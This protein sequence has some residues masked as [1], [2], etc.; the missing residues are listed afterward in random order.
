M[1]RHNL[2]KLRQRK[3]MTT[4]K[5]P[6]M[7]IQ[8]Y[9]LRD[10]IKT[11][12][13]FDTTLARL[14]A[15]GVRD[16]QISGIGDIPADV[17][18]DILDKHNI[19]VCVTHKSFDRM[20]NDLDALMAEHKVIGCDAIG[21]G[22]APG[23][24]RGNLGKVREFIAR[25]EKVGRTMRDNGFTFN[26]HNHSAEF[27]RLGDSRKCMM[28]L[29]IDETDP[30]LFYFI[31][32]VAWV[33]FAEYNPV[34]VLNRMKSRVKVLHFKD[35]MFDENDVR[36]FVPLGQGLVNLEDCYRA[37]CEL[38]IPYI[39]YEHDSD[40]PDNDPFKACEESWKYMMKLDASYNG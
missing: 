38:E 39:M 28:D 15:M 5:K 7:G 9:T 2:K 1:L 11:A 12:E 33:H 30:E 8:L 31:P 22:G 26:Y 34:D 13:D 14:E 40:W 20:E 24:T 25:A 21:I 3:D 4:M 29:L 17:Q 32:D 27:Y 37:A 36:H 10:H 18:K 16:V 35:Y 23:D 19:K 6:V